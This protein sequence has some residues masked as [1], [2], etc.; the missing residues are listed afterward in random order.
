M[1]KQSTPTPTEL[2]QVVEKFTTMIEALEQKR[3][4]DA[5]RE[6]IPDDVPRFD[7]V[8]QW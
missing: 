2:D 6:R 1:S 4:Q 7:Y 5:K 3:E 8:E